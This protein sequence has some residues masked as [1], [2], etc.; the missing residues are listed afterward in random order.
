MIRCRYINLSLSK[1]FECNAAC[2]GDTN[3]G[4]GIHGIKEDC[5]DRWVHQGIESIIRK[6]KRKVEDGGWCPLGSD[7]EQ[8]LSG[9]DNIPKLICTKASHESA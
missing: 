4:G 2:S 6:V 5:F 3:F 7:H 9:E 1:S 8:T